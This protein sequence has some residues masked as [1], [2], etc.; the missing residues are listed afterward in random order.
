MTRIFD[1]LVSALALLVLSPLLLA[2][3]VAVR[4]TSRGP[5]FHRAK[6]VGR[7][8]RLFELLKFRSM[9]VAEGP[10]VTRAGDPR[11]TP[12][13]RILRGYKLDELPQLMNVLRGDM[14][15]VGPRPEDPKYTAM[16]DSEQRQIL[17]VR[18]G[19]TSAASLKYRDE[20]SHLTGED[21]EVQYV[22]RIMPEKLKIDLDYLRR[23]TFFSDLGLL[24]RTASAIFRR[25]GE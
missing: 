7:D 21:W 19:I 18:P 17:A 1:T 13:G 14:S 15:L 5:A 9:V 12:L 11:V 4:V 3:A 16:Y 6:R 24:L 23:R 25:G 20:E 10:A 2:I 8:G 22:Q